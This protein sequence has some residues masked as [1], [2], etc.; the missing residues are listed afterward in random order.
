MSAGPDLDFDDII[1]YL[2]NYV[3][4]YAVTLRKVLSQ[5]I[6]SSTVHAYDK[7]IQLS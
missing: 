5:L 2:Y 3:C 7:S 4:I 6:M 1:I